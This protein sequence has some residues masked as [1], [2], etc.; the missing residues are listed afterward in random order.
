V[1]ADA[2]FPAVTSVSAVAGIPSALASITSC[3]LLYDLLSILLLPMFLQ[4]LVLQSLSCTL[5][6]PSVFG[7]H[8]VA[9]T[10]SGISTIAIAFLASLLLFAPSSFW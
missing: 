9:G 2:G 5:C 1:I 8:A 6:I 4:L 3:C 7:I 10:A